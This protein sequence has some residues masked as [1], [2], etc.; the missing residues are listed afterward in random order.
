MTGADYADNQS[1]L[2]DSSTQ[3][4]TL[5]HSLQQ[6]AIDVVFN[7]YANKIESLC[8]KQEGTIFTLSHKPLKFVV[9]FIYLGRYISSTEKEVNIRLAKARAAINR[10]STI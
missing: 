4:E 6:T 5:L 7:L 1:L 3:T 9:Q 10:L 8:F 2:A